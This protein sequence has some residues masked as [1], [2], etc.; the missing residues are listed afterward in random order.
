MFKNQQHRDMKQRKNVLDRGSTSTVN[1]DA[2][3][4][5]KKENVSDSI[6]SKSSLSFR[7]I[8]NIFFIFAICN[9][10][11]AYLNPISDCD[12]TFNYWEPTHLLLYGSGFQTWEY[13]PVYGLRSYLYIGIHAVLGKI[14]ILLCYLLPNI[15]AS[16]PK[17]HVFYMIRIMLGLLCA[18]CQTWFINGIFQ[19][20]GK[21]I[22][23]FTFIFLIFSSGM[24]NAAASYLP[25]TFSMY[26]LT[27]A[28]GNWFLI[29]RNMGDKVSKYSWCIFMAGISV[30]IGWPFCV[31]C[32]LPLAL[33]TIIHY[34]LLRSIRGAIKT[35]ILLFSLTIY[36]D[37][38]FYRRLIITPLNLVLYNKGSG[39]Q[40]YGVEPWT[41]YFRNMFLNFNFIFVLAL[42]MPIIVLLHYLIFK[43]SPLAAKDNTQMGIYTRTHWRYIIY[44]SPFY[45]WFGF[46]S[47]LPHK[48]ERF[49]FVVYPMCCLAGA[50]ALEYL[51]QCIDYVFILGKSKMFDQKK[52]LTSYGAERDIDVKTIS[53]PVTNRSVLGHTLCILI[54]LIIA[55]IGL[56]R[57][58]NMIVSY[59]A[60]LNI[61]S[62]LSQ[63]ILTNDRNRLANSKEH[64]NICVGK[65]W[66]RF[67][68]SFFLPGN[69]VHL[70]FLRSD[71]RGLLPKP[72]EFGPGERLI[73]DATSRIPTGMNDE[74]REEMDRYVSLDQCD[75]LVDLD[76]INQKEEHYMEDTE[77]W[78]TI[79]QEPFLDASKSPTLTRAF[80]IPMLSE[81]Q[82]TY[83]AYVALQRIKK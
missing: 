5:R 15:N 2:T 54:V 72:F 33:D 58:V 70:K 76:L 39:S 26:F 12:E 1:R 55:Y 38:F 34:G 68:S 16:N 42:L 56:S 65:E 22:A 82:N 30:I 52:D 50:I 74:N 46:L 36:I 83:A 79:A 8:S 32:A 43:S 25:S 19:R 62:K 10:V 44:S 24:F 20:F 4:T 13:S 45:I 73:A 31:V 61:Y 17:I 64:I 9:F 37:R 6:E 40:L 75:Y 71:F 69:N 41:F 81:N 48:E 29:S 59:R 35:C 21:R 63:Y 53:E 80:Y 47:V 66:Y 49:L 28:Y 11:S 27:L 67:P 23:T 60:P 77:H 7:A 57:T 14:A 51:L 18:L 3:D 78:K